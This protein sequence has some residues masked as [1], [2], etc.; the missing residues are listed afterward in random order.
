MVCI[1]NENPSLERMIKKKWNN[2]IYRVNN[3]ASYVRKGIQNLFTYP[4]FRQHAI[5]QGIQEGYHAHRPKRDG[6]Y[7]TDNLVFIPADEHRQITSFERRKLSDNDV[8]II[9]NM[10][11]LGVPQR[12]IA[13]Q[14]N[15]SQSLIWRIAHG[16][17]YKDVKDG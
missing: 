12:K 7:S 15:C 3:H 10:S 11:S 4:E 14:F 2:L 17:S 5:N 1:S 16:L 9:R 6:H 8:R 13:A